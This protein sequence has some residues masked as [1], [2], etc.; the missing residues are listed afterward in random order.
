MQTKTRNPQHLQCLELFSFTIIM[1]IFYFFIQCFWCNG[2]RNGFL[3]A[4][5][6]NKNLKKR[7]T[8]AILFAFGVL[9][10]ISLMHHVGLLTPF[11]IIINFGTLYM[12]SGF[13]RGICV[14]TFIRFSAVWK[15]ENGN[16]LFQ[17]VLL[18]CLL[19][20][21]SFGHVIW[22]SFNMVTYL[23]KCRMYIPYKDV[24]ISF[25]L[26]NLIIFIKFFIRKM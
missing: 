3:I 20:V 24:V 14:A 4:C 5:N 19:H 8:K 2:F 23:F 18:Y 16:Y 17:K 26:I 15:S 13:L 11:V 7:R 12:L 1:H 21:V 6:G 10:G 9:A 22:G 25:L